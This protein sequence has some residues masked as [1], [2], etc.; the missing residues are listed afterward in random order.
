MIKA[1]I[2]DMDGVL[3]DSETAYFQRRM[4]F[5]HEINVQPDSNKFSDY[6][7][8]SNQKVWELLVNDPIK[9]KKL[10]TQYTPYL[11]SHPLNYPQYLNKDVKSL[12][13]LLQLQQKKI[14]LASA[15]AKSDLLEMLD[16]CQIKSFFNIVLSGEE[17]KHNKP[18]PDIYIQALTKTG[19]KADEC[20]V[21]EDSK[22]GIQ[23][24]KAAGLT[25]WALKPKD[26]EVDQTQAD[27]IFTD[28]KQMIA[29][30]NSTNNC[31][32]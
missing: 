19:C 5:F 14:V 27:R 25:V 21:V 31:F 30:L 18:A 17:V 26:Y 10:K 16:E 29:F 8:C 20:I 15:G 28:F 12:L 24:A 7:G 4:D 23:A 22:Y 2:F 13:N 1:F 32:V 11:K 3:I 9:R 6:L